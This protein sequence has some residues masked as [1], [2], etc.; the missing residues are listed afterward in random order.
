MKERKISQEEFEEVVEKLIKGEITRNAILKQYHICSRTMNFRIT[1][2]FEINPN[3]YKR[4]IEKFPYK[5]REITDINFVELAKEIMKDGREIG[6]IVV[7]YGVSERTIRRRIDNMKESNI[8]DNSTGMTLGELYMLYKRYRKGELSIEDK[9]LINI[10]KIGEIQGSQDSI[11]NRKVYLENLLNRYEQYLEQGVSKKE[12][13]QMLGF[14]TSDIF[15]RKQELKRIIIERQNSGY[16]TSE[17][18]RIKTSREK[19]QL[20]KGNL[21]FLTKG[22]IHDS[23][24]QNNPTRATYKIGNITRGVREK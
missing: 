14:R 12:A 9:K 17:T 20:F 8:I 4:F 3:L 2:L 1:E 23:V 16:S 21:K 18:S 24:V 22:S 15:K 6:S 7:E 10:M 11:E 5:P 19:M 13:A